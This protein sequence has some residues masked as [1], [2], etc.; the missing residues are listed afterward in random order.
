MST[1]V[2]DGIGRVAQS[3]PGFEQGQEQGQ[4]EVSR[5]NYFDTVADQVKSLWSKSKISE[6]ASS[7]K[8]LAVDEYEKVVIQPAAN[9]KRFSAKKIIQHIADEIIQEVDD[10]P[11][12][13]L[14]AS[15]V[16]PGETRQRLGLIGQNREYQNGVWGA[17]HHSKAAEMA[18]DFALRSI[19]VITFIDTPGADAG[20]QANLASQANSISHLIT[21][22]TQLKVPTLGIVIGTGYSGGA[23]PLAATNLLLSVRDGLFSTI[24]PQGLANIARK[25]KLSW[26]QCAQGVGVAASELVLRGWVDGI[27]DYSPNQQTDGLEKIQ[28]AIFSALEFIQKQARQWIVE[29]AD[30][31][32]EYRQLVDSYLSDNQSRYNVASGYFEYGIRD[33]PNIFSLAFRQQR[34]QLISSRL[35]YTSVG[36][37]PGSTLVDG[38]AMVTED[39]V[40]TQRSVLK[41]WLKKNEKLIYEE[42]LL[43]RYKKYQKSK[44]ARDSERNAL[45]SLVLGRP[46][47]NYE[48]SVKLLCFEIGLYLFNRWKVNASA[49][50]AELYLYLDTIE[51]PAFTPNDV[52]E[53]TLNHLLASPD[54][55][56]GLK[57][58]CKQMQ[59]FDAL[60]DGILSELVIVAEEASRHRRLSKES[61]SRL[62]EAALKRTLTK[63]EYTLEGTRDFANWLNE[64]MG[65]C[66]LDWFLRQVEEWK[67]HQHAR[68]SD[69]LFVFITYLFEKIIPGYLL[70]IENDTDFDGKI[71]PSWIGRRKDF[72]HRLSIA[73]CDLQIQ[74]LQREYKDQWPDWQ[75]WVDELCENFEQTHVNWVSADPCQFPGFLQSIYKHLEEGGIPAGVITGEAYLKG[76]GQ[77]GKGKGKNIGLIISNLPFQAGAL[78]M[79]SGQKILALIK[80]CQDK[81]IPLVG[82]F[83]SGGMQTKEGA[84]ALF[85][86]AAVNEAISLFKQQTGLPVL[87]VGYGDCTGGAQASFVT[88]PMVETWYVSGAN[89]PFAGQL[90]VPSYLPSTCTLANYLVSNTLVNNKLASNKGAMAGLLAHPFADS[91]DKRLSEIDPSMEKANYSIHDMLADRLDDNCI[92]L[93]ENIASKEIEK[94]YSPVKKL[95]VHARGCTAVK[96]IQDAHKIRLP[97]VLVQ[98]DPDMNSV[99]AQMLHAQDELICIGGNTPDESYLNANSVLKVASM[100]GADS[101]HPGIGFLSEDPDFAKRCQIRGLNFIGPDYRSMAMMGD[102][103]I[104]LKTAIEAG[105]A[106]VPGSHGILADV[107]EAK[108]IAEEIGFPLLLKAAFGGGGKGIAKLD[109]MED[110]AET[111]TRLSREAESAF[112]RGSLYMER[113]VTRMRHIE[114]QILRDRYGHCRMPG[115]RDCSVQRNNQKLLEE[116][117]STLL[118]DSLHQD[119]LS[120]AERI[121]HAS[122]YVGAGTVEFIY[123]LKHQCLYFMEMNTRLQV[124]HPVTELVSGIDIVPLQ[125]EIAKGNSIEGLKWHSSGY[126]I[127]ARVNAE[128]VLLYK[129]G[130]TCNPSPGLVRRLTLPHDD[131]I[132]VICCI[133]SGKIVAPF[134]DSLIMQV[135]ATGENRDEARSRLASFLKNTCIDGIDTNIPLLT[136]VLADSV[137]KEGNYDTGY[138]DALVDRLPAEMLS[139]QNIQ[140]EDQRDQRNTDL[141]IPGTNEIKVLSPVTSI[142]YRSGT[143]DEPPYVCEGDFVDVDYTLCL[144]ESMKVFRPLLLSQLNETGKQHYLDNRKYEVT[145]VHNDDGQHVNVGDLLFVLKPV[146]N[147]EGN[148]EALEGN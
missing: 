33:F 122:D 86:M 68:L 48:Q 141:S 73:Y 89:I 142:F 124:E 22:M 137:F 117:G 31:H 19:P 95:L 57:R 121:A 127:E 111:F 78:D 7:L 11:L 105:V 131:N 32:E 29:N 76:K 39:Q 26:Q 24:Q 135:V 64:L 13:I 146:E 34:F 72:W 15:C 129:N 67:Q 128:Q 5:V 93:P 50:F 49:G 23:I 38:P 61:V 90:V 126:A 70:A 107:Q 102:K 97:I 99:P 10:G 55:K 71:S 41:D 43:A 44:L 96:L 4:E 116:S 74:S 130:I 58:I 115:I 83:S 35:S 52:A 2:A 140:G 3:S 59:L 36:K 94:L 112:G 91:F 79:A 47:D 77:K 103:S 87:F 66:E 16:G 123:D 82:I 125:I 120:Y 84:G 92:A 21:V 143:P 60:Y 88:H 27:I 110:L 80:R 81:K 1:T 114:V 104:A 8:L 85:S 108:K 138:L 40:C 148:E 28:E 53:L 118:P 56:A 12:Y 145:R 113:F 139:A 133:D 147:L 62:L 98:S 100:T 18:S 134:Y 9:K 75:G 54:L 119:A 101:L 45:V 14:E 132:K 63:D 136:G 25:Q 106:V 37:L 6:H 30:I 65:F 42:R 51:E 20:E 17:S 46:E 109:R 69:S 144:M